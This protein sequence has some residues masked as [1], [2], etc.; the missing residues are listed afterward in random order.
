MNQGSRAQQ[1]WGVEEY[2]AALRRR[3]WVVLQ[4]LII[5][6]AIAI[7]LAM[8]QDAVYR[9]SADVLLNQTNVGASLL[10]VPDPAGYQDPRRFAETQ[11]SLARVPEV[12]QRATRIANIPGVT[13]AVLL[14]SSYAV[15]SRD[16]DMLR[17]SVESGDPQIAIKLATAYAQAFISYRSELSTAAL[18]QA[19]SDLRR[20]LAELRAAGDTRTALYANLSDKEQELRTLELLQS[21]HTLVRRATAAG[22]VAPE[23]TRNAILGLAA[24]ILIGLSLAFILEMR[25][26]RVRSEHEIERRLQLPLLARVPDASGF[27]RG[28]K[29]VM[30]VDPRSPYAEPFRRLRTN[31]EF[32]NTEG[33]ARTILVTSAVAGEGKSTTA[34]NL[35]VATARAGR[36]VVLVDLDLRLPTLH[37]L[38]GVPRQPGATDVIIGRA[39]LQDVLRT[40]PLR[41]VPDFRTIVNGRVEEAGKLEFLSVGTAPPNPGEFLGTKEVAA[42]LTALS[43]RA[44]LVLVDA[45]PLLAVGDTLPLGAMVDGIVVVTRFGVVSHPML[46]DLARVL[47]TLPAAKLG[48]VVTGAGLEEAYGYGYGNSYS[49]T[50]GRGVAPQPQEPTAAQPLRRP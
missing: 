17:F 27:V 29:L 48:F 45:P 2:L 28:K 34:G 39:G 3:K 47:D 42:L 14:D 30:L 15:P 32:V 44:D 5:V 37:E 4:A 31:I 21:K 36:H 35:A 12:A 16:S 9:S 50:D 46:A 43:E 18:R 1:P 11:A 24:G 20:R 40:V 26:R 7:A 23:P 19:R 33:W 41:P 49:E 13:P 25:D 6:P 10:G 8:R 22:Q 38:L